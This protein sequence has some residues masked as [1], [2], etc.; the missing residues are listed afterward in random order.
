MRANGESYYTRYDKA[1]SAAE[2]QGGIEIWNSNDGLTYGIS[3]TP[4]RIF[5]FDEGSSV[6][7]TYGGAGIRTK[8]DLDVKS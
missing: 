2:C 8:E 3:S 7:V 4:N 6:N 5:K 1:L